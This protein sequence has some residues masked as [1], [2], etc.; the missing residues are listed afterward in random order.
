MTR[1]DGRVAVITGGARGIGAETARDF[2][3]AGASVETWD[4]AGDCDRQVDVINAGSV[5]QA[6]RETIAARGRIGI[7]VNNA[8]ILR[9]A[10]LVKMKDDEL[11][12]K[13]DEAAWDS[14][15]S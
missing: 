12:G 4:V 11:V 9:D 7:L 5:D 1:I 13:M 8:G 15:L 10:Q 14:V 2:R 6:V 3:E